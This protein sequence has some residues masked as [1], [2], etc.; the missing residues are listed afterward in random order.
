MGDILAAVRAQVGRAFVALALAIVAA[1]I[2]IGALGFFAYALHLA[3]TTIMSE[4]AAAAV[5]GLIALVL[6]GLLL[7]IARELLRPPRP[8][9]PPPASEPGGGS[10]V[11]EAA[12]HIAEAVGAL[13]PYVRRNF[14]E[15]AGI[16]FVAGLIM[17]VSPRARRAIMDIFLRGGR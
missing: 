12:G 6:M 16:A 14:R 7:L 11:S 2:G 9:S 10:N 13:T 15:A 17:G 4:I 3:L 1:V 5:V 8:A